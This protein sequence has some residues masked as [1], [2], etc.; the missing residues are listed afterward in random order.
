MISLTT[1]C[2]LI[3]PITL[4]FSITGK[5]CVSVVASFLHISFRSLFFVSVGTKN[6]IF[7]FER[8]L[9]TFP[10]FI[11]DGSIL[12]VRR[13]RLAIIPRYLLLSKTSAECCFV[14]FSAPIIWAIV[15]FT[16]TET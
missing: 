16:S 10:T 2:E 15:S 1:S 5:V 4:P 9:R 7:D 12:L 11:T 6:A 8:F 14:F 3:T 13:Y